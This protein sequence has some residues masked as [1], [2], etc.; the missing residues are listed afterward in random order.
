[1]P[2]DDKRVKMLPWVYISSPYSRGKADVNCHFQ[3]QVWQELLAT[4]KVYPFAPIV[5]S[6]LQALYHPLSW[7]AWMGYD[8]AFL[9]MMIESSIPVALLR[10]SASYAYDD[11]KEYHVSESRGGDL[12]V[13]A[14]LEGGCPVFYTKEGLLE[15]AD[16]IDKYQ[17]ETVLNKAKRY[18]ERFK[19]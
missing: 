9:Q 12:E 11:D 3:L 17:S 4:G 13:A 5:N 15:W 2:V 16:G 19:P 8:L 6:H 14:F 10:L 7:D 18:L 1:M